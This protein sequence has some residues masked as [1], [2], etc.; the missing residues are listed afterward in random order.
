MCFF[1]TNNPIETLM[2]QELNK[3]II[4]KSK[5]KLKAIPGDNLKATKELNPTYTDS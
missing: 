4:R 2:T 1:N 3:F 5:F